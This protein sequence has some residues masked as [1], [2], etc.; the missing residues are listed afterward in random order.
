MRKISLAIVALTAVLPGV[1]RAGAPCNV[2]SDPRGDVH[3]YLVPSAV[4]VDGVDLTGLDVAVGK[5]TLVAV[6]RNAAPKSN[7]EISL[8]LNF[9]SGP[10]KYTLHARA[11]KAKALVNSAEGTKPATLTTAGGTLTFT[12]PLAA[13]GAKAPKRG[14]VI[15]GLTFK[16]GA[17]LG[18]GDTW[19]DANVTDDAKWGQTVKAGAASCVAAK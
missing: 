8:D 1:A 12:V 4:P 6:F 3:A 5:T 11:G 9:T 17:L 10:N 13:F 19:V 14:A 15:S 16:E 18:S 7:H 2:F